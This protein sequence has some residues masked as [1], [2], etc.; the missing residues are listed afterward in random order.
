MSFQC[1][2][3]KHG[4]AVENKGG[5]EHEVVDAW[6]VERAEFIPLGEGGE[7][8][9]AG[10]GG[11]G[12]GSD[13]DVEVDD[14]LR[15]ADFEEIPMDRFCAHLRIVN[16]DVGVFR[17]EVADDIDGG[18]FTGVVGVLFEG[19]SENGDALAVEVGQGLE[20]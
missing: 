18:G 12:I 7:G 2:C 15:D 13:L 17:D 3:G 1:G 5:L 14:V 19:E 16:D 4:A 9:C 6:K 11:V 20:R 8:V 10:G